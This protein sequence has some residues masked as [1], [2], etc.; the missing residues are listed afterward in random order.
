MNTASALV[1]TPPAHVSQA[2][3]CGCIRCRQLPGPPGR[4]CV[5]DG[6]APQV[7]IPK[8]PHGKDPLPACW[9]TQACLQARYKPCCVCVAMYF[10]VYFFIV[11]SPPPARRCLL[12]W[13]TIPCPSVVCYTMP[14]YG[15]INNIFFSQCKIEEFWLYGG[16]ILK[17]ISGCS[18]PCWISCVSLTSS[19]YQRNEEK[20]I[21]SSRSPIRYS[22]T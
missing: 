19:D 6:R 5:G 20:D 22:A 12:L 10:R 3:S 9:P 8:W 17:Q 7:W 16:H 11:V 15:F 14:F 21:T 4:S 1:P 2:L 13:F 18:S